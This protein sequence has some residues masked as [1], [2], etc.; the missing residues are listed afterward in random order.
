MNKLESDD[1]DLSTTASRLTPADI[2]DDPLLCEIIEKLNCT[3]LIGQPAPEKSIMH[4][5]QLCKHDDGYLCEHRLQFIVD[6]IIA[7]Y[8]K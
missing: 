3:K 6:F 4:Y 5:G 8:T 7:N 1:L 2:K